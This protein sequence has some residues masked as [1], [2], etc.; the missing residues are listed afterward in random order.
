MTFIL[1]CLAT[2]CFIVSTVSKIPWYFSKRKYEAEEQERY[3]RAQEAFSKVEENPAKLKGAEQ[4]RKMAV[5]TAIVV[6]I[7]TG[8]YHVLSYYFLIGF[9]IHPFLILSAIQIGLVC[10]QITGNM[11]FYKKGSPQLETFKPEHYSVKNALYGLLQIAY[12][13]TIV[14]LM[15]L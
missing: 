9:A 15:I 11:F 4:A 7:G 2:L 14:V 5:L 1:W 6:L 8:A 13:A 10:Y 3:A 12:Y